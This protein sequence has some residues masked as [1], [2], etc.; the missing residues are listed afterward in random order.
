MNENYEL[1]EMVYGNGHESVKRLLA[2]AG[3]AGVT[4][5]IYAIVYVLFFRD[6][7][8]GT[9]EDIRMVGQALIM[10]SMTIGAVRVFKAGGGTVSDLA[11]IGCLGTVVLLFYPFIISLLLSW[12]GDTI[13]ANCPTVP[14]AL[15]FYVVCAYPVVSLVF[16]LVKMGIGFAL[17][18]ASAER[19]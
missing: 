16:S 19:Y 3:S 12:V 14:R 5:V 10:W 17:M 15:P 9:D 1:G 13:Y 6:K 8:Q 11:G 2:A 4:V 7:A 18:R